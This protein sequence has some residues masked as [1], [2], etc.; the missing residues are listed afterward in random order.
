MKRKVRRE[1]RAKTNDIF[2][3][4]RSM[5][6]G[7]IWSYTKENT[8]YWNNVYWNLVEKSQGNER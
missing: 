5:Q 6:S 1:I 7:F 8:L 4:Y 2:I 3:V